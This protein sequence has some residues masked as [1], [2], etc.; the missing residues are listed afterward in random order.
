MTGTSTSELSREY[1]HNPNQTVEESENSSKDIKV[2]KLISDV[3]ELLDLVQLIKM[4][5]TLK[6]RTALKMKKKQ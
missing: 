1:Q 3:K 6:K 2:M 4:T 5:L